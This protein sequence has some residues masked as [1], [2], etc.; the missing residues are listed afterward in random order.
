MAAD[1]TPRVVSSQDSAEF[2]AGGRVRQTTV[3]RFMVGEYGPFETIFDRNP[4]RH[5]IEA[6]MQERRA[7]LEGLC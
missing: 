4:P 6:A 3:V 1:L 2:Q 5:A 7:A